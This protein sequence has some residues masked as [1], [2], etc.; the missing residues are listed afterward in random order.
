MPRLALLTL[1]ALSVS[2][3]AAACS[4]STTT[5]NAGDPTTADPTDEPRDGGTG[6]TKDGATS[7]PD[8]A[9]P[10][11]DAAPINTPLFSLVMDGVAITPTKIELEKHGYQSPSHPEV[12]GEV[13]GRFDLPK[14]AADTSSAPYITF[15]IY[16]PLQGS[17]PYSSPSSTS[18]YGSIYLQY[19]YQRP[20][21]SGFPKA[22]GTGMTIVRDG[23]DGWFEGT[24]TGYFTIDDGNGND[25]DHPFTLTLRQPVTAMP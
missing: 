11:E 6:T 1:A 19:H 25:V 13:E 12:K 15:D 5:T 7:A 9:E 21:V 20:G 23:R 18:G 16:T 4:G 24:A 2:L 10:E 17:F 22:Q 3:V 14:G 8:A